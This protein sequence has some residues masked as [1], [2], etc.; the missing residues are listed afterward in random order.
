MGCATKI[1]QCAREPTSLRPAGRP[2]HLLLRQDV[3]LLELGQLRLYTSQ[4]GWFGSR[5]G[6][7]IT[8]FM[9]FMILAPWD[10]SE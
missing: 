9:I 7:E 3:D 2:A 5:S 8:K 10:Y 4:I 1:T 6:S